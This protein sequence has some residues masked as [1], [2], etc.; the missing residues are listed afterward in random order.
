MFLGFLSFNGIVSQAL[1]T[2]KH[3]TCKI[4]PKH[5]VVKGIHA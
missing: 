2:Q 3:V 4:V 1:N 5:I